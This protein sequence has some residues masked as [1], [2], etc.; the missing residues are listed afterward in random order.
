VDGIGPKGGRAGG[1][2]GIALPRLARKERERESLVTRGHDTT[3]R[4]GM[5]AEIF[6]GLE[7]AGGGAEYIWRGAVVDGH[8]RLP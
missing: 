3:R 7:N 8:Q 4:F 6:R 5:D 2:E 1:L